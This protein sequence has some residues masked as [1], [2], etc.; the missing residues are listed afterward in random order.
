VVGGADVSAAAGATGVGASLSGPAA[1]L[2]S[3]AGLGSAVAAGAGS[4]AGGG[5][6]NT[7]GSCVGVVTTGVSTA[8]GGGGAA[9]TG[10]GGGARRCRMIPIVKMAIPKPIASTTQRMK[11]ARRSSCSG[12]RGGRDT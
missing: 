1:S 5:G 12:V 3:G 8:G 9:S 4:I 2:A 6:T 11:R 7:C 10:A